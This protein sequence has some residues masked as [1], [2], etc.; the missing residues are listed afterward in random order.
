MKIIKNSFLGLFCLSSAIWAWSASA[1]NFQPSAEQINTFQQLSP[2]EREQLLKVLGDDSGILRD[3]QLEFPELVQPLEAD[4]A[5]TLTGD[6]SLDLANVAADLLNEQQEDAVEGSPGE[7]INFFD[8]EIKLEPFGY[9]LFAGVPTT[10]APAT[11]IPVPPDY[12][13]GPGDT[14]ELQ[15]FGK[16]NR[17]F[18]LVVQRDGTLNLPTIG[19]IVVMGRNFQSLKQE[20]LDRVSKDMIGVSAAI[21]M[22]ALRS[23]RVL[24]VGD[25]RR[26]GSY[27]VS[28]L[29]T[30]SN[31]LF[32]SGGIA[33][34]G[35][36]R[37]IQ[38]RRDGRLIRT[39]DLYDLL[40]RGNSLD[41]IRLQSGDVVFIPP[42]GNTIG[43]GGYVKRPAIYETKGEKTVNDLIELAGG[44]KPDSFPR[45]ARLERITDKWERSFL[46]VDL[47]TLEGQQMTVRNGDILLVPPVLALYREGIR[48]SG[49]VLRPG[50]FEWN[51]GLR[52]TDVIKSLDELKVQADLNYILIK[53]ETAPDKRLKALSANLEI[54]LQSPESKE[55]IFLRPRDIITVFD[56]KSDRSEIVGPLLVKLKLQA[57]SDDPFQNVT[58]GGAVRSPG[59]YPF[60]AGMR[61][62]DLLRAGA[63][64]NERANADDAEISRYKIFDGKVRKTE[65]ISVKPAAAL[66]GDMDADIIL[67]PYDSLQVLTV[68][69]FRQQLSIKLS[70]EVRFPGR[71]SFN[72]GDTLISVIERAGGLTSFAFPA[73]GI[74]LREELKEREQEQ[75]GFLKT[76]LENDLATLSIK[77]ANEDNSVQQAELAGQTLLAQ[78]NNTEATGRLVIDLERMLKAPDNSDYMVFLKDNDELSIP[79]ATQD[80]TVL[81]QVQF[82]TSHLYSRGLDRD[83]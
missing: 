39:L 33:D 78:I 73:G 1:Q 63:K 83:D 13:I 54:A 22:G 51:E 47:A 5:A 36:L 58:I 14:I 49:H 82:P 8:Q 32:V 66:R 62:S 40:I 42:V 9:D 24:V 80:V 25:A 76:R 69:E 18:S 48:L 68:Q 19:P 41:D 35:S 27:T 65:V 45:G 6:P 30:I 21:S 3:G 70:G 15:F 57:T 28:G 4:Q 59:K 61:L 52:L 74:F 26:P 43:V 81:G 50:D 7:K 55:N 79:Q 60:E 72:T 46:R 75:L 2:E 20:L 23:I 71:Y 34:M 12:I 53:R 56:L 77:A 31:L 11:D 16:Q 10:F 37:D 17:Q 44:L 67:Q 64:M 29:S 38:V